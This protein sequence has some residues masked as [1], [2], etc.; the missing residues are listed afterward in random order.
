[1]LAPASAPA[2]PA[3]HFTAPM[4]YPMVQSMFDE[5]MAPGM[6]W[7]WR[8]A[9]FDQISDDAID[10]H[11]HFAQT[12]PTGLSTMHLYPIDGAAH[13]MGP[14]DTAWAYRDATWSGVI[15]GIDPDPAKADAI[16]QWSVEYSDALRPHSMGGAY[17]NFMGTGEG[18]DRIQATYRDHYQRLAQVKAAYDPDNFF[19]ANQNVQPATT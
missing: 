19:H 4:P 6:Q 13:Q 2:E 8:G 12:I 1:M 16:K 9:F 11:A 10:V 14:D 3:F 18:Q 5:L 17:V 7:Y 15:A